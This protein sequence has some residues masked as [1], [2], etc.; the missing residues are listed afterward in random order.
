MG[1]GA[2]GDK[3]SRGAESTSF[4][5]RGEDK[6]KGKTISQTG[7]KKKVEHEQVWNSTYAGQ[8]Q[9]LDANGEGRV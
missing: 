8:L 7:T 3:T 2:H 5:Y 4:G 1:K 6:A 9:G